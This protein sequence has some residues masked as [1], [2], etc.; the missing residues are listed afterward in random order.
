[1]AAEGSPRRLAPARSRPSPNNDWLDGQIL[2]ANAR[3]YADMN[4]EAWERLL[5][6]AQQAPGLGY[7][8]AALGGVA[9]ARGWSRRAEEE[10]YIAASIAPEDRGTEVALA[11]SDL[12]R[13]DL[14]SARARSASLGARYPNDAGVQRLARDIRLFDMA[15]LRVDLSRRRE[16]GSALS[17]PG[18][19]HDLAARLYSSPI[20]ERWRAVAAT[21]KAVANPIEG[22]VVR[23][24][25]GA[26][27]EYAGPD[28]TVEALAWQNSG[29]LSRTGANISGAWRPTDHWAAYA[30]AEAYSADTPLRAQFYGITADVVDLGGEY[31]WHESRAISA[32]V[33]TAK[34]SDGNQRQSERV[35]F[36]QR[37]IDRP[38]FD[39]TLR[40]EYYAS[41]N[42]RIGAP[43]FNP[44]SDHSLTL[45]L[46]A[47]HVMSRTYDRSW[48]QRLSVSA[49][50]YAQQGFS[51]GSVGSVL[52]E[53]RLRLDPT[54][55]LR[56]GLEL[57]KRIYDGTAERALIGFAGLNKRF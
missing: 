54:F 53:Q 12:R 37:L 35:V 20:S 36:K 13:L 29:T 10:L 43:Y 18:G 14:T 17:A 23:N 55:E 28:L 24:R 30:G 4:A 39:L 46:D 48:I 40:P 52:Y 26:G 3:Q 51:G 7:L 44:V 16:F 11:E 25:L 57:N 21:E 45:A 8:R 9:A 49:G 56:Y 38:H 31:R 2:A 33:R 34:F 42:S 47:E 27:A 5:P 22:R 6:L 32:S 50:N 1:M 41:R 15:E 19:G